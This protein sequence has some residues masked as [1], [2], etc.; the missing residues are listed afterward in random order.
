MLLLLGAATGRRSKEAT[1]DAVMVGKLPQMATRSSQV[2]SSLHAPKH[3][4]LTEITCQAQAWQLQLTLKTRM[5][6]ALC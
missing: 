1:R 6:A 5:W 2:G 3:K 4:G